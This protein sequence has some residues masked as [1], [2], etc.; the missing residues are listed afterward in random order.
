[1]GSYFGGVHWKEE[2]APLQWRAL[3]NVSGKFWCRI[4]LTGSAHS[5]CSPFHKANQGSISFTS[6]SLSLANCQYSNNKISTEKKNSIF[7]PL[8]GP[9]VCSLS[10]SIGIHI[11]ACTRAAGSGPT[12]V[13]CSH[14]FTLP[15]V[16]DKMTLS[17]VQGATVV[18]TFIFW[19][20]YWAQTSFSKW[21]SLIY[22]DSPLGFQILCKEERA[23]Y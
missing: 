7:N 21:A 20:F 8:T 17:L 12:T 5:L 6:C 4:F 11:T 19:F 15:H 1:M 3:Q 10:W 16:P 18:V 2:E 14:S 13:L 22:R 23:V 9:S